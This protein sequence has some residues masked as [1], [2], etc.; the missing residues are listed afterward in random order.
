MSLLKQN[1]LPTINPLYEHVRELCFM[2]CD[3][4]SKLQVCNKVEWTL[5]KSSAKEIAKCLFNCLWELGFRLTDDGEKQVL[6]IIIMKVTKF[7]KSYGGVQGKRTRQERGQWFKILVS[8]QEFS[9]FPWNKLCS[10]REESN[11]LAEENDQLRLDIEESARELND[12]MEE[13]QALQ[14]QVEK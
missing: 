14:Q 1:D 4:I 13:C 7:Q 10:L 12:Q 6:K 3:P 9:R 8:S 2:G 5:R 11:C